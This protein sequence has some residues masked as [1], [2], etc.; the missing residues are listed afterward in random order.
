MVTGELAANFEI[1]YCKI[2]TRLLFFLG[3]NS[4]A[5][6]TIASDNASVVNFYNATGSLA[7]SDNNLISLIKT[8]KPT[9]YTYSAGVVPSCKFDS[10]RIGP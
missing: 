2:I 7:R 10:R 3:E 5:N 9:T 4:G 8:L 1:W 6:P